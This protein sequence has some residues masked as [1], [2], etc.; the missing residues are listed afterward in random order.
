MNEEKFIMYK[1][2]FKFLDSNIFEL[3]YNGFSYKEI[4]QLLDISFSCVD[5]RLCKIR[6]SLQLMKDKF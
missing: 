3:R 5:S 6:K 1:N 4:S 2:S